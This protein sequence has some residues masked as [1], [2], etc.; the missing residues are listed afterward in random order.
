M[1]ART[2]AGSV[3]V[4]AA[5]R[6][7][8]AAHAPSTGRARPGLA[9]AATAGPVPRRV[10]A[11]LGEGTE[12]RAARPLARRAAAV[13]LAACLALATEVFDAR[14]TSEHGGFSAA[15]RPRRG[16]VQVRGR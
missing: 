7:A 5:S 8:L 6:A 2:S 15:C 16:A 4:W 1:A 10:A 9:L 14:A 13:A 12:A 11:L 3:P